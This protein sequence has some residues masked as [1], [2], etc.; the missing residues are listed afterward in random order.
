MKTNKIKTAI[1]QTTSV[2]LVIF[3]GFHALAQEEIFI[4]S[5]CSRHPVV[6]ERILFKASKT[7][8]TQ[9]TYEELNAIT[10]MNQ[11]VVR[12]GV[13]KSE[14]FSGLFNLERLSLFFG[15]NG[16]FQVDLFEELSH[17]KKL[18]FE[19]GNLNLSP[20]LFT[21]LTSLKELKLYGRDKLKTLPDYIFSSMVSLEDL[22]LSDH[23]FTHLPAGV[24]AGLS[25]LIKL[26]LKSSYFARKTALG[27]TLPEGIFSNLSSLQWL[28]LQYNNLNNLPENIF[29]G[30]SSLQWLDLDDTRLGHLPAGLFAGLF[31]LK[32]LTLSFTMLKSVPV[33]LLSDLSS[34]KHLDLQ[35]NAITYLP[36]GFFD[37]VP[38]TLNFL[39]LL[40]NCFSKA[41]RGRIIQEVRSLFPE[42]R[43][44]ENFGRPSYLKRRCNPDPPKPKSTEKAWPG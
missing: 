32:Y 28:N 33:G 14:D 37:G 27:G 3:F 19:V 43:K 17:L 39:D 18:K 42:L 12:E 13:L 40:Y 29:Q 21:P 24:F 10:F 8:C 30:L 41:E 23:Y 31:S 11:L 35:H 38:S 9:V 4:S 44:A 36:E 2:A 15:R 7:D 34:L 22:D 25:S 1:I 26:N 16:T 20:D 6:K 5:V